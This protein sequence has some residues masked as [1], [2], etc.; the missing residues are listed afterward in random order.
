MQLADL[1]MIPKPISGLGVGSCR[2]L[3]VKLRR[4]LVVDR[5]GSLAARGLGRGLSIRRITRYQEEPN[6][7]PYPTAQIHDDYLREKR[8][9]PGV[10]A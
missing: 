9:D 2:T 8:L 7:P 3:G 6:L 4:R 10:R 1:P 5:Q